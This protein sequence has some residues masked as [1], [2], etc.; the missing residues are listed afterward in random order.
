MDA[1]TAA[2]MAIDNPMLKS[3]GMLLDSSMTYAVIILVLLFL[4]E[5]RNP[6]RVKVLLCLVLAIVAATAVKNV[7]TVERPCAGQAWCHADYSFP[8]LHAVA[9]F[10]LMTAFLDKK[11]FPAYL[12]FALLICFTRLNLGVHTFRDVAGALPIALIAYYV[13]DMAW[14]IYGKRVE[15]L[16]GGAR[17]G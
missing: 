15:R 2:A 13:T 1:I 4:G 9:A 7:M 11:A 16:L 5:R 10:A 6:K 12:A 14:N 3:I 8:S 17:N